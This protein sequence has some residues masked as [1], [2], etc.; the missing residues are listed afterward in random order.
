MWMSTVVVLPGAG[1]ADQG[2]NGLPG[3]RQVDGVAH[4]VIVETCAEP[5]YFPGQHLL[6]VPHGVLV[7]D[8]G[9]PM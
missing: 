5:L 7:L 2:E 3:R 9:T 4:V 6:A 8:Y 1:L